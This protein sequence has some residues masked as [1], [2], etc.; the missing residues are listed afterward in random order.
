[1]DVHP[2]K[3]VSIGIDPYP[4][5]ITSTQH[6][7]SPLLVSTA[8]VRHLRP[9]GVVE[10][11]GRVLGGRIGHPPRETEETLDRRDLHHVTLTAP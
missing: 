9:Q 8:S 11:D 5:H 6:A 10:A 1:M 4:Y 7:L 2:T 3:N